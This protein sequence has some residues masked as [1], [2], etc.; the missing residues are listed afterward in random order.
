LFLPIWAAPPDDSP[1]FMGGKQKKC[2]T[3]CSAGQASIVLA[4][5]PILLGCFGQNVK[6]C[7]QHRQLTK[8]KREEII[9]E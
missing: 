4:G 1:L 5:T 2:R 8:E 7:F 3:H 6:V 9:K